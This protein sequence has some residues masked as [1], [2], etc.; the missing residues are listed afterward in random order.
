MI[1][2]FVLNILFVAIWNDVVLSDQ[3]KRSV[4]DAGFYDPT[5]EEDE[6]RNLFPFYFVHRSFILA[7]ELSS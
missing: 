6:V 7:C 3:G 2:E 1:W 4:Y 5:E